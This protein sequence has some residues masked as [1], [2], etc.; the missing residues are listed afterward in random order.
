MAA[1]SDVVINFFLN[2]KQ[3]MQDLQSLNKRFQGVGSSAKSLTGT[4]S[5]LGLA[6]GGFATIRSAFQDATKI[7]N[8]TERWN[9]PVEQVSKFANVFATFG[10]TTDEA[11]ASI[12]KFQSL[13]NN[14]RFHSSGALRD[15]SAVLG[16]NL[17]NQD[18]MGIIET[19]RREFPKLNKNAQTEVLNMLGMDSI[20]LQR[21]LTATDEEMAQHVK[22]AERMS[23]INAKN[24]ELMREYQQTW[25]ELRNSLIGIAIPIMQALQPIVNSVR[26]I[27]LWFSGLPESVKN[28]S[29]QIV[30]WGYG[31]F[32]VFGIVGRI[33]RSLGIAKLFLQGL[34]ATGKIAGGAKLAGM[35]G[36]SGAAAAGA[37]VL[38]AI[39]AIAAVLG[40]IAA[41]VYAIKKDKEHKE[42]QEYYKRMHAEGYMDE[43]GRYNQ[44]RA[45]LTPLD[46]F[47]DNAQRQANNSDNMSMI[48]SASSLSRTMIRNND[49]HNQT[50][51]D[52]GT[53]TINIYGV[54]GADDLVN[55]LQSLPNVNMTP[56]RGW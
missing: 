7:A 55:R 53:T 5:K 56:V 29:A 34:F 14:L 20:T 12:E 41:L 47:L 27:A 6:F 25:A 15:L 1:F 21:I 4:L 43:F 19:L 16:T 2:A 13:A 23:V 3:A 46:Q 35:A 32:K 9:L 38:L 22:R 11:V 54:N 52:N 50:T 31:L 42:R 45:T 44:S 24:V 39:A 33:V 36:A 8:L 51:I 48:P 30:L 49:S 17:Y 28:V 26:D 10:G 40:T 37:P 18:Y